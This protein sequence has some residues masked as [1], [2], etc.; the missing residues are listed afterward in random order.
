MRFGLGLGDGRGPEVY[1]HDGCP[2]V[3]WLDRSCRVV[4]NVLVSGWL[5]LGVAGPLANERASG[6]RW[7]GHQWAERSEGQRVMG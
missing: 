1:P 5:R 4:P 3:G 6:Q 7:V 2:L